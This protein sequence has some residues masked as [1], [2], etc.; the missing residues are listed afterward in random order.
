MIGQLKIHPGWALAAGG[1]ACGCAAAFLQGGW[2]AALG[3]AAVG[4]NGLAAIFGYTQP[5]A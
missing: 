5:K 4:L 2:V 3:A 1:L